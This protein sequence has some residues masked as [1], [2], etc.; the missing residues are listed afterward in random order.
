MADDSKIT[1]VLSSVNR[2]MMD[3]SALISDM[4]RTQRKTTELQKEQEEDRKRKELEQRV[5]D[6]FEKKERARDTVRDRQRASSA[7]RRKGGTSVAG[8][9]GRMTLLGLGAPNI[10]GFIE[11]FTKGISEVMLNM[12]DS[13]IDESPV[14]QAVSDAISDEMVVRPLVFGIMARLVP[15]IGRYL[16]LPAASAGLAQAIAEKLGLEGRG[17]D[18]AMLG[19]AAAGVGG[20]YALGKANEARLV[21]RELRVEEKKARLQAKQERERAEKLR[22]AKEDAERKRQ[23][24]QEKDD[25]R[26]AKED[27]KEAKK[28]QKAAETKRAKFRAV[29]KVEFTSTSQIQGFADGV[30]DMNK[31]PNR[32]PSGANVS[33]GGNVIQGNF[34]KMTAAD[35]AEKNKALSPEKLAK[36]SRFLNLLKISGV[37]SSL[38]ALYNVA[39]AIYNDEPESVVKRLLIEALGGVSG[40]ILGTAAGVALGSAIPGIGNL[41]GGGVGGIAGFLLGDQLGVEVADYLLGGPPPNPN[42]RTEQTRRGTRTYF[43]KPGDE[44]YVAPTGSSDLILPTDASQESSTT[45]LNTMERNPLGRVGGFSGAGGDTVISGGNQVDNSSVR[46]GDTNITNNIIQSP[47]ASLQNIQPHLP[48]PQAL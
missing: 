39:N 20:M 4:Q 30:R 13:P 25:K 29:P 46:G 38:P 27:E 41:V 16:A 48:F 34:G 47:D 1:D 12:G 22:K 9:L 44:G 6:D 7:E 5:T 23:A 10:V 14:K 42:K 3:Q 2:T 28:R 19:G 45:N 11:G 21:R 24:Q 15:V 17:Q 8:A 37:V 35:I 18:L 26:R 31:T 43:L 33:P 32:L 40:S 36:Y